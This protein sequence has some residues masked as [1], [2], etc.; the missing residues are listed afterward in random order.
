[1]GHSRCELAHCGVLLR[2]NELAL[3]T[4]RFGDIASH[5]ADSRRFSSIVGEED[6]LTN[7]DVLIASKYKLK[8]VVRSLTLGKELFVVLF[9]QS[10]NVDRKELG[11]RLSEHLVR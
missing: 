10:S 4:S 1:M 5:T 3:Q 7:E 11:R 9:E 6:A 8:L 2:Q